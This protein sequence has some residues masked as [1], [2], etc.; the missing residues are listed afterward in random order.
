MVNVDVQKI[1]LGRPSKKGEGDD[2]MVKR[3]SKLVKSSLFRPSQ[4]PNIIPT[5]IP[6][7]KY[8]ILCQTI[9]IKLTY[10]I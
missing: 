4:S 2:I 5:F 10:K 9:V 8:Y 7:Y 3:W 6:Q 1:K